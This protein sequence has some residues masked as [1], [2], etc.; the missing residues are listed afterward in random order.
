MRHQGPC[1]ITIEKLELTEKTWAEFLTL[2]V[3]VL[4]LLHS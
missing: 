4:V 3:G 2:D 1:T